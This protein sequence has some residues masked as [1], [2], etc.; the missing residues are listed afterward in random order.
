[1]TGSCVLCRCDCRGVKITIGRPCR[2]GCWLAC[3]RIPRTRPPGHGPTARDWVSYSPSMAWQRSKLKVWLV[4]RTLFVGVGDRSIQH[5]VCK[6]LLKNQSI[7]ESYEPVKRRR[8]PRT[9]GGPEPSLGATG[10]LV[11]ELSLQRAVHVGG[12]TDVNNLMEARPW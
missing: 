3:L 11:I 10:F 1:M 6:T 8:R 12:P 5:R 7:V 4:I 2:A 9:L